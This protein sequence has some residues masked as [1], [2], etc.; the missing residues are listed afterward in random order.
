QGSG[1]DAVLKRMKT[2]FTTAK[3]FKPEA[4]RGES[5]ETYFVGISKK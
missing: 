2:L 1:I 5:V 4:C 3:S